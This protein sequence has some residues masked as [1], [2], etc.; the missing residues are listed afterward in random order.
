MSEYIYNSLE[1]FLFNEVLEGRI[2]TEETY[3][4]R[5]KEDLKKIISFI[6]KGLK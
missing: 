6:D 2:G 5:K 1:Y 4:E 3:V